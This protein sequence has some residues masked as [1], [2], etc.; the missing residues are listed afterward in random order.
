MNPP[1]AIELLIK[2]EGRYAAVFI[3]EP[4]FEKGLCKATLFGVN[5][6]SRDPI[7][8]FLDLGSLLIVAYWVLSKVDF[9]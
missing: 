7:A 6:L 1:I 5:E 2:T 9:G 4:E 8:G 3:L